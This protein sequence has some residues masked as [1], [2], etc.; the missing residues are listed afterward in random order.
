M[1]SASTVDLPYSNI[2]TLNFETPPV[3]IVSG[4]NF[5]Y[6]FLEYLPIQ[7][8]N[9]IASLYIDF[10]QGDT[11]TSIG[12]I[13]TQISNNAIA[14]SFPFSSNYSGET[15]FVDME[16]VPFKIQNTQLITINGPATITIVS[17]VLFE[18]TPPT[19]T[20]TLFLKAI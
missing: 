11:D 16:N 7:T 20:G 19:A 2:I 14:N 5:T 4:T 13:Q 18:N 15:S 12:T 3:P 17:N 1:S 6:T 10:S 8:G 9:Y